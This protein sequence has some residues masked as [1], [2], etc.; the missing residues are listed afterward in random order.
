MAVA[1]PLAL[2]KL[3]QS[4]F[5]FLPKSAQKKLVGDSK[6]GQE[7]YLKGMLRAGMS[8]AGMAADAVTMLAP[9]LMPGAGAAALLAKAVSGTEALVTASKTGADIVYKRQ[10]QLNGAT[11]K[12]IDN[13]SRKNTG[14]MKRSA[15][16]MSRASESI[17]RA[18]E[19]AVKA[20]ENRTRAIQEWMRTR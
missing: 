1:L 5:H 11:R 6:P 16:R 17:G 20:E 9:T 13:R 15:D 18:A 19:A 2:I 12:D 3:G 7:G 4:T 10:E 8:M 14:H